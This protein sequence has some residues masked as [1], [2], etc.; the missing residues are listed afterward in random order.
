MRLEEVSKKGRK[1]PPRECTGTK[2]RRMLE[3]AMSG[4]AAADEN[5]DEAVESVEPEYGRASAA[6]LARQTMKH[7]SEP[8][9]KMHA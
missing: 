7:A 1:R 5:D 8:E 9:N 3:A 6:T 2:V 4:D